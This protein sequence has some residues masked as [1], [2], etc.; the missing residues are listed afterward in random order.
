MIYKRKTKDEWE[1]QGNYGHGWE[2]VTVEETWK[3][4][5]AQLRVYRE[6][7]P[8]YRHRA[9]KKRVPIRGRRR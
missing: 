1:I 9:I 8:Q 3:E 5:K 4:A 7:E 6:N 2:M